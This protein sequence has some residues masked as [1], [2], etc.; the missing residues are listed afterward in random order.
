MLAGWQLVRTSPAMP[1]LWRSLSSFSN[2]NPA[3][4]CCNTISISEIPLTLLHTL[5]PSC[6]H[7]LNQIPYLKKNLII[8]IEKEQIVFVGRHLAAAAAAEA[9]TTADAVI[10]A[11]TAA[12]ANQCK[13]PYSSICL[14][15]QFYTLFI[16][17]LIN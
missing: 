4:F 8:S 10:A 3:T 16:C 5:N 15:E 9:T 12:A 7:L 13:I 11:A 6:L 1:K 14:I 2:F 17:I